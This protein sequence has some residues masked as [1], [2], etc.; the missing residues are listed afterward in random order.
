MFGSIID[1]YGIVAE[2]LARCND[3]AVIRDKAFGIV[4]DEGVTIHGNADIGNGLSILQLCY[5]NLSSV[6]IRTSL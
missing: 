3:D 6:I 2:E 4:I 1:L 5:G